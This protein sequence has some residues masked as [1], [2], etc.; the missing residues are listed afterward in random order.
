MLQETMQSSNHYREAYRDGMHAVVAARRKELQRLRDK[1]VSPAAMAADPEYWR[2]RLV[3]MLGWPLT[4]PRT[5]LPKVT[6][7]EELPYDD[8]VTM[9]RLQIEVLPGLPFYGLLFLPESDGPLPLVISQHGGGG[10]PELTADIHG[11][12]NYGHMTAR[13]LKR[14]CA[15]FAP[16]LLLWSEN[17]GVA[18]VP[19]YGIPNDRGTMESDLRQVGGSITAMELFA[20][21][22][23]LDWLTTLPEIQPE[24]IG[25]IGLSY[26]GFYTQMLTAV[27]TRIRVGVSNAFFNDRTAYCWGD[28]SWKGSAEQLLDAE[29]GGLVAPRALCVHIGRKDEVFD[30]KKALPE[31]DRLPPFFEAQDA[32]DQL[33]IIVDDAGHRLTDSGE[34]MDFLF[35]HL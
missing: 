30:Y 33:K 20:L 17:S 23:S 11:E 6:V 10:S 16:Q 31:L 1:V 14:G 25:M 26:G 34:E 27:D 29:I 28:F 18:G 12:N 24:H 9:K 4:E 13:L 8:G 19:S 7:C 3:D 22:R 2:D 5:G 15:V 32:M 35:E 21:Q